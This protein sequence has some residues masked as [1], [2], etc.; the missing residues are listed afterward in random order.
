MKVFK[1]TTIFSATN[2]NKS[3]LQHAAIAAQSAKSA[4]VRRNDAD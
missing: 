4:S 3:S 1:T 2:Y